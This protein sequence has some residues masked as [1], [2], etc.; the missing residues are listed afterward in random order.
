MKKLMMIIAALSGLFAVVL[1]AY[2]AHG[3]QGFS[4]AAQASYHS[5]VQYQFYHTL[6]LLMTTLLIRAGAER[7]FTLAAVAFVAG[8]VLFCG[9]IYLKVLLAMTLPGWLTPL[10][11]IAFMI[12]WLLLACGAWR[13]SDT[14]NELRER[15]AD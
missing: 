3:L 7:W 8:L 10:G 14:M 12:G 15:N 13:A 11:G 9:S 4:Q 6:A 2:G 1:G 5:A